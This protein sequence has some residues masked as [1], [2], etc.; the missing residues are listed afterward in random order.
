M[1]HIQKKRLK[2]GSTAYV[3]RW[4]NEDGAERSKSFPTKAPASRFRSKVEHDLLAGV[5]FDPARGQLHFAEWL[6][7]WQRDQPWTD[8][9]ALAVASRVENHIVPVLGHHRI[10]SLRP[11]HIRAWV[12][13]RHGKLAPT[14]LETTFAHLT[15]S[16]NAAVADRLIPT[17]PAKGVQLPKAP[18]AEAIPLTT[19]EVRAIAA[20]LPARYRALVMVAAG[21]GLRPAECYGLA[22][23]NVDFLRREVHVVQQVQTTTGAP[24]VVPEL[25]SDA[26]HRT[27][28]VAEFV[29]ET[30]AAHMQKFPASPEGIIFTNKEGRLIRRNSFNATWRKA[31]DQVL[32]GARFHQCRHHYA[33][34]LISRGSSVKA[35]QKAL[36]HESAT[37]TLDTYAHLWP[38]DEDHLRDA[39]QEAFQG[40]AT[41]AQTGS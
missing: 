11:S 35:V 41:T 24:K 17:N 27:V 21:T 36:G 9:T 8:S 26:A 39:I 1:A 14:T 22:V 6:E 5:Y 37:V 7:V 13:D 29:I 10:G 34:V 2:N 20:L 30:I 38:A 4:V 15:S 25:K 33:S 31:A 18:K 23:Q 3:V 12:K 19:P 28:P 40:T 32:V 16:L